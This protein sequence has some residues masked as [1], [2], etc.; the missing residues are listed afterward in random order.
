MQR[1]DQRRVRDVQRQR[2]Y[3]AEHRV[4]EGRVWDSLVA[5]Q[6]YLDAL[7][8]SPWWQVHFPSVRCVVLFDQ[9]GEVYPGAQTGPRRRN[10]VAPLGT[11]PAHA[12]ART[13]PPR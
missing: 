12:H 3:D 10:S 2:L 7:L 8:V 1:K 9:G 5:A 6:A 4:S 11:H 13:R